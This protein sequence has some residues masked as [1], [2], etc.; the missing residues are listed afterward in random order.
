MATTNKLQR[1]AG[2]LDAL[3]K[4]TALRQSKIQFET[5]RDQSITFT[6][7][8]SRSFAQLQVLRGVLENPRLLHTEL[9]APCKSLRF[10]AQTLSQQ[11][12]SIQPESP[13]L[14][15]ALDTLRK[16]NAVV[17]GAVSSVWDDANKEV[18]DMTQ[19]LIELT[20]KFDETTQMRL[21]VALNDFKRVERPS[22]PESFERYLAARARLLQIRQEVSLPGPVGQ[23]LSNAMGGRGSIGDLLSPEVQAFLESHPNLKSRLTVKLS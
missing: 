21:Q 10:V 22:D 1:L 15:G 5:I 6:V 23:F 12:K 18:I 16:Q 7:A 11:A 3:P 8:L 13:K 20:A 17:A 14:T 19:A 2:E 9:K 4:Q